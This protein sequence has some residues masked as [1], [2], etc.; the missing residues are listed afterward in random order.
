[1]HRATDARY[2]TWRG[3]DFLQPDGEAGGGAG[4]G[5]GDHNAPPAYEEEEKKEEEILPPEYDVA[6]EPDVPLGDGDQDPQDPHDPEDYAAQ[7]PGR[8]EGR[9]GLEPHTPL[10]LTLSWCFVA[11]KFLYRDS[12]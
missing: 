12:I 9:E 10:P 11:V 4:G 1:M 7:Q 3:G 8:Q 6:I 5:A 2:I